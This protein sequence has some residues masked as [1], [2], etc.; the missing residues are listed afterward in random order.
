[1]DRNPKNYQI[2]ELTLINVAGQTLDVKYLLVEFSLHEDLFNNCLTGKLTLNDAN[3][4]I[5][6]FPIFGFEQCIDEFLPPEKRTIKVNFEIYKVHDRHLVKDRQLVYELDLVSKEAINNLK[7]RTSTSYKNKLISEMVEDLHI[8]RLNGSPI[9]IETT[10][11][12]HHF[13]I[14]NIS[15]IEA[16]NWLSSMAVSTRHLGAFYLY[17]QD[18]S[19]Y[20][21]V[22]LESLLQAPTTE[23]YLLH[24]S[25]IRNSVDEKNVRQLDVDIRGIQEIHFVNVA[26]TLENMIA[27]MYGSKLIRHDL[28]NKTFP[29]SDFSYTESFPNLAH[30]QKFKMFSDLRPDNRTSPDTKLKLFTTGPKEFPYNSEN[31]MQVRISQMKSLTNIRMVITVP[32]DSNR[33]VGDIIEIELPSPE[34]LVNDEIVYDKYYRG[35][36]LITSLKHRIELDSYLTTMEVIKD[37]VTTKYP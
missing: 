27:G 15:P 23:K 5:N 10:K 30:V 36:F 21:F 35:R 7:I 8:K 17:F 33:K 34:S 29:E 26:D 14:P 12:A 19:S 32:G 9:N 11:G 25:N 2:N 1:M 6:N 22:S 28:R 24:P 13:I 16:I 37:S 4:E 3:N 18:S 20:N 31:W